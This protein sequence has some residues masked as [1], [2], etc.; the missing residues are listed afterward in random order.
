[1]NEPNEYRE[2]M[3][4]AVRLLY[5]LQKL[6][7]QTGNRA[8]SDTATLAP[9]AKEAHDRRSKTL[10]QLER[11]E[12]KLVE[13]LEKRSPIWPWLEAQK[14]CGPTMSGVLI[15]EVDIH[16]AGTVSALWAYAGLHVDT[17]T[18]RAPRPK[19]GER[20]RYNAFLRTKLVG[21]LADCMIKLRSPWREY[22]DNYKH[23][24]QSRIV[25][26]MACLRAAKLRP[27][28]A[29]P[30]DKIRP[31]CS[32]CKGKGEAPWG[33][34]DG[35]RNNASKRYMI[36]MF[37]QAMWIEWRQAEGLEVNAPY[38]DVYL[39]RPHGTH[40]GAEARI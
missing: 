11:A 1:M 30:A 21:V 18:G 10:H 14:G 28:D 29:L 16:R 22:Y 34:S 40:G 8:G 9:E 12:L 38:K 13:R 17:E 20:L 5:D 15:S 24:L 27:R 6:R 2:E 31:K 7:I 19:K 3:R 4:R 37:L 26:C 36:K 33:E 23:R 25:P 35:H 32:Q 39:G